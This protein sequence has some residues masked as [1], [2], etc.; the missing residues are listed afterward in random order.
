MWEGREALPRAPHKTFLKKGFMKS[1]NFSNKSDSYSKKELQT[2]RFLFL[3]SERKILLPIPT[4]G[5][6]S[7]CMGKSRDRQNGT[8][9]S[10][11]V[12]P[13]KMLHDVSLFEA[14]K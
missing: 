14:G 13:L 1:K 12:P 8:A 11:L 10:I 3:Y 5:A 6:T 4:L 9:A 7:P 2:K